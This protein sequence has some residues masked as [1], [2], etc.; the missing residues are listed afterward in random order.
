MREALVRPAATQKI[1]PTVAIRITSFA[2]QE[3]RALVKI[4]IEPPPASLTAPTSLAANRKRQQHEPADQRREEHRPPDALGGRDRRAAGLLGGM[5]RGVVAGLRVHGQQESE[6][7]HQEPERQAARR[8]AVE[9]GVVDPLAEDEAEVLV[10]VG[11]EDRAA[12]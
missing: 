6:R 9:A 2:A 3:S 12:R 4:A 11:N 5:R 10:V 1:W 7:Q 8:A